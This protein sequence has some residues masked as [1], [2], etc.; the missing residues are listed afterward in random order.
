MKNPFVVIRNYFDKK[1]RYRLMEDLKVINKIINF[2]PK[3]SKMPAVMFNGDAF[4]RKITEY[5][6]W[7][8][9][10]EDALRDFF[11]N[12]HYISENGSSQNFFWE[13]CP[14]D[15]P[16]KHSGFPALVS[17]KMP[18]I[19]F[20]KGYDL[21]VEVFTDAKSKEPNEELSA[22]AKE[23]LEDVILPQI[24]FDDALMDGAVK[25]SWGGHVF[26]KLSYDLSL[27]KYP[28]LEMVDIRYGEEI[29]RRG[30]V[31]GIV[32][33]DWFTRKEGDKVISYRLDETYRTAE[34]S[35]FEQSQDGRTISA[36]ASVGDAVIEYNLY[37]LGDNGSVEELDFDR[38]EDFQ[39][40]SG[41]DT[42]IV[43]FEGIKGLL[44]FSKPNKKPNND[45]IDSPYGASDYAHSR[46]AFDALD[47]VTS[48]LARET[49]DNKSIIQWP[50]GLLPK[51][52]ENGKVYIKS[53][54]TN[55]IVSEMDVREGAVNEPHVFKFD[56]KTVSLMEKYKQNIVLVCNN[57]EISPLALGIT[58]LES[59]SASDTSQRERNKAT[60]ELRAKKLRYWKP[61][62]E[63]LLIKVLELNSWMKQKFPELKQDAGDD[64]EITWPTCNV[65]VNFP[66]Y[67]T[68]SEADLVNNLSVAKNAN[69][70]S[71]KTAVKKLHQKDGWSDEQIDEEVQQI[72]LEQNLSPQ[73]TET[74]L[75]N[76]MTEQ[77]LK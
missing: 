72:L 13:K 15:F 12:G 63:Q 51:N 64:I 8:S 46:T 47:E 38:F 43:V 55:L 35:D 21:D 20:S 73:N 62:I 39:E 57:A 76:Q 32:F 9:G 77:P 67:V 28:I 7:H 53:F 36:P 34:T 44:A 45:F 60:I 1:R 26:P 50:A 25:E 31:K 19:L 48:E 41:I 58:G 68:D 16:M 61:V 65:K 14:D 6:I 59:I 24:D 11:Q 22:K 52:T 30:I 23:F 27:S 3:Y 66:D 54:R 29:S 18:T 69:L 42:P 49:R 5:L 56:D 33:H 4:T 74:A 37:R 75:L 71:I 70:I 2:D 10:N 17:G 40:T